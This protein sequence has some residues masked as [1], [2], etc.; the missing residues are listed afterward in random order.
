MTPPALKPP[1]WI[2]H[3]PALQRMLADI[4]QYPQVAVDTE[5]NSLYA[6]RE[7]V[8]LIQFSTPQTDY[9]LDPLALEDLTP[10]APFFANPRIEKIFHA[11]EYDLICLKRDFDFAFENIFD[12]MQAARILGYPNIGLAAMLE[13][14][15]GIH[16][17]KRYQRA[18]WGERPLS[19]AMLA[20][21]RLDT[22]YLINL[23]HNLATR[24]EEKGLIGLAHEDFEHLTRV[25]VP[26]SNGV[27]T[28]LWRISGNRDLTPRQIAMLQALVE[29]RDRKA[30][31]GDL[32]PFKILSNQ[33]LVDIALADPGSPEELEQSG[34]LS[35][36]QLDRH[37]AGIMEALQ[38]GKTKAPPHRPPK[39][40][41]PEHVLERIE[42]LKNWRKETGRSLGVESDVVLPRDLLEE[43]AFKNP[44]SLS[45]LK[46]I[47]R[48]YP[49]RFENFGARILSISQQKR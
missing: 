7:Q 37:A 28:N 26:A 36:R 44:S 4:V 45:Q 21:A 19:P 16:I 11:A 39:H 27:S 14:E 24:L 30:R 46:D 34:L 10:L 25:E 35:R 9:L 47:M 40:R 20:Y 6:Y 31:Q 2:A 13:A 29:Y 18:N 43:I 22:H 12:T 41:P 5:S 48:S 3:A 38:E 23:R 8:C 42:R 49:W 32:P 33:V 1:V 15:F 17:E